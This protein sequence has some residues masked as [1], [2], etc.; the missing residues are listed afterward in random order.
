M[1]RYPTPCHSLSTARRHRRHGMVVLFTA[2]TLVVIMAM[3]AFSVD[4]GYMM[5]AKTELQ[6]TADTCALAAVMHL[7]SESDA[8][9]TAQNVADQNRA[10]VGPNLAPADVEVG[11][12]DRDTATFVTP[13]V[14]QP[15]AV[16]VTLRR[17]N[18]RGNPLLLF[19]APVIGQSATDVE[20]SAI[21]HYDRSLCGP[22][23]GI[24]W[25]SVPG[26]SLTDS[27]DSDDGPYSPATAGDNGSL[28]SDGPIMLE[29]TVDVH[30]DAQAGKNSGVTMEGTVTLT[31]STGTRLKPLNMPPVDDTEAAAN[32][33]NHRIPRIR[34][35][36]SWISPV[37]ANG[38]F[39][40]DGTKSIDLPAGTYYFN[41]MTLSGQATL[42]ITGETHIYI[43]GDLVRDGGTSVNNN[44][45][46]ANNLQI[47]MTGGTADITSNDAFYGV[48][49]A[50]ET[51]VR[52]AGDAQY[53]GA[54]V[55]RTLTVTGTSAGHYD[56][57]LNLI[58][59]E[60]PQ[61][62]SLVD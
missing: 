62:T 53:F 32:N 4:V 38:N 56:E 61:R 9:T 31:G 46:I 37:D 16:R 28:C 43:A 21:A 51:T 27:F 13:P 39:L 18:A 2:V 41:D 59:S 23:V 15:D 54:V 52:L 1:M 50:P 33:D 55:G 36:N 60:L 26:T 25:L 5:H 30:G 3:V 24:D 19:F 48:I 29:G 22:F 35:G 20:A 17:T 7:P 58:G 44:T 47:Y 49:Y 57:T 11:D 42:N 10:N 40:L 45:Q 34:Q 14:G 6:R 12:W 8:T